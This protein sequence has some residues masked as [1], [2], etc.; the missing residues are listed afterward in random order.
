MIPR[1]QRGDDLQL[2]RAGQLVKLDVIGQQ[3]RAVVV[4]VQLDVGHIPFLVAG[5]AIDGQCERENSLGA[6]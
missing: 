4:A 5:L 3:L 6:V 2:G 1:I